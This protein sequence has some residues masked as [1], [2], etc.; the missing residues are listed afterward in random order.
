MIAAPG[1]PG[2]DGGFA[3]AVDFFDGGSID[4]ES[5]EV[6]HLT[7][8]IGIRLEAIEKGVAA[9]RELTGVAGLT[10]QVLNNPK[11][12][13]VFPFPDDGMD[14]G[15][16]DAEVSTDGVGAEVSLGCD[17]LLWATSAFD[18]IP[19]NDDMRTIGGQGD[20]GCS[21]QAAVWAVFFGFG[22]EHDGRAG[23]FLARLAEEPTSDAFMSEQ[24]EEFEG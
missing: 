8:D 12:S 9:D 1:K 23:W 16:C 10:L 14:V 20:A 18:L 21:G 17:R 24:A 11:D 2:A 22:P 7:N 3:D 6:K 5:K 15:I 19:G 13:R 4:T